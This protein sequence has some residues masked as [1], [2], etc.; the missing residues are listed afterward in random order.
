MLVLKLSGIKT[1][2]LK[3]AVRVSMKVENYG[4]FDFTKAFDGLIDI[5][6]ISPL[7]ILQFHNFYKICAS[8]ILQE[9]YII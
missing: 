7:S 4:H 6:Y 5:K 8:R 3:S 9:Y 1:D 2:S